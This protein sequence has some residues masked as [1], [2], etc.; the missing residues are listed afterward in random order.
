MK[1]YTRTGDTGMTSV[2]SGRVSKDSAQINAIG[3]IDTLN[4][5]LGYLI[6]LINVIIDTSFLEHTQE[7]LFSLGAQLSDPKGQLKIRCVSEE[8]VIAIEQEIDRL[9]AK[10]PPLKN[11]I[12][13]RGHPIVSWTHV[14]RTTCREAERDCVSM[15]HVLPFLNRLSDYF[16]TL[17]R[18]LSQVLNCEEVI[19]KGGM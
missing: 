18:Y 15:Q 2:I 13:P 4:T 11:F 19:W 3:K 7:L 14:V 8:D 17:A 10:L 12:L 6:D 9:T 1:I 16:F 5:Q